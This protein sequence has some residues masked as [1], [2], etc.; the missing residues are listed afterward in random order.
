MCG[1]NNHDCLSSR[2]L[3]LYKKAI[4]M[5][6]ASDTSGAI[7]TPDRLAIRVTE[8]CLE[9]R[10]AIARCTT[11]PMRRA[12]GEEN[13]ATPIPSFAEDVTG[14]QESAWR[15]SK[16]RH[17]SPYKVFQWAVLLLLF[18]GFSAF[19]ALERYFFSPLMMVIAGG[20]MLMLIIAAMF[21]WIEWY[22]RG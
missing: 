11:I 1:Y 7:P 5:N 14:A 8:P 22:V 15:E 18:A 17:S 16:R 19:F 20:V 13:N 6:F 9:A 12:S 2:I 10:E 3:K 4:V 21:G